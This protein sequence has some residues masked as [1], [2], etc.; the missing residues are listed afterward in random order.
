MKNV[1]EIPQR[2]TVTLEG[3]VRGIHE[4]LGET[5]KVDLTVY[6]NGSQRS[7]LISVPV[8]STRG[9]GVD[10]YATVTITVEDPPVPE[11]AK[12]GGRSEDTR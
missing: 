10:Q 2:H 8:A 9:F 4:L 11:W 5:S 6:A 1:T 7:T 12:R 3:K